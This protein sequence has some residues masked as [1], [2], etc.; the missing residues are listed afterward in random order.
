MTNTPYRPAGKQA[1]APRRTVLPE[2]QAEAPRRTVLP[3]KQAEARR[4][5]EW[6][7]TIPDMIPK[8]ENENEPALVR[9]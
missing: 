4:A 9:H 7:A 1:E 6:S 2:K 3:E 8:Q 5:P